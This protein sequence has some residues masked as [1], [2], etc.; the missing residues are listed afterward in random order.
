MSIAY[1]LMAHDNAAQLARLLDAID[2]PRN[3]V[4]IHIDAKS[5][6]SVHEEVGELV[7]NRPRVHVMRPRPVRWTAYSVVDAT[8]E[9]MRELLEL[10]SGWHHFWNLSGQDF[11]L[12]TQER[13][14]DHLDANRE[15]NF[16]QLIDPLTEWRDGPDRIRR[17]QLEIPGLRNAVK[18]PKLRFDRWARHL[19]QRRYWGGSSYFTL[20]RA[21]CEDL[22]T[23]DELPAYKRFFRFSYTTDEIFLPTF[24][25]NTRW[26]DTVVN[27]NLRLIDFSEG[28]IRPRTWTQAHEQQL[29]QSPA[30]FARKFDSR[31]DEPI[32]ACVERHLAAQRSPSPTS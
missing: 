28:L 7:R 12:R 19:Q 2:H 1:F 25:M 11:P 18:I 5:P 17:V 31:I 30:Y 20:T 21:L 15:R 22:L 16:V 23:S 29:L 3:R 10:D 26:R 24:V 8:L 4:L 13:L 32:I 6:R 14:I 9:G 27:D